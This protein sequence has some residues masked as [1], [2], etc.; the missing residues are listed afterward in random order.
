MIPLRKQ[1]RRQGAGM[2]RVGATFAL[3]VATGMVACGPAQAQGTLNE[4]INSRVQGAKGRLLVE[5]R[6]IVYDNDRNTVS[7]SGDVELNYQGRT[8]QADRVVY[9][10]N[11]GRVFAQG[12]VRLTEAN[13]SV[14][15][16]DQ[17]DLTDDFKSG[18]INSLQ[19]TQ[20]GVIRGVAVTTRFT[21]PRAERS[22][23]ETTTFERGTYTAC[24]PCRTA[25]EKPP[26]WQVKAA[27]IIHSNQERTIYY[28]NAT[29][30][31][32]GVP[33]A[34]LP[35][36]WSPDPTV[37]R[38]TGFLSPHFVQSS[39]LGTGVGIPFF[40][41]IA[42]NYDLT[43]TPTFLSRQGVLGQ[44]EFRHRLETGSYSIRAA[45]IYQLD[46][47]AFLPSPVGARE[48]DLRGSLESTG[49]FHINERWRTGW[50]LALVS[51][52]FFLYNYHIRSES[53]STTYN[54][55]KEA[56]STVFL[57]GQ[58]DRSWFDLRGYY[59][60]GLSAYDWQKQ[61]PVVHPVLDYDKRVNGPGFLGG[62]VSVTANL[63]SLTRE[64][65]AYQ[66][67]PNSASTFLLTPSNSGVP[68]SIYETCAVFQRGSCLVRGISGTYTRATVQ[69][70]WR[71]TFID[72]AGQSWTPFAYARVDGYSVNPDF[73]GYQNDQL[74]NFLGKGGEELGGRTMPAIGL[75]Y[76]YPFV[77]SVGSWGTQTVEPIAQVIARPNETRIG[78]LPNEDAQSLIFDDTN[79][80]RLDKFS[81]YDRV[82]GGVRANVGAQYTV[83]G[84]NQ[85]YA[86]ALV[87]QSFNI[88]GR[89]SFSIGDLTNTGRDSGL[90]SSRSDYVARLAVS[91]GPGITFIGRGRFD[92][93]DFSYR[94]LEATAA[95]T[96]DPLIPLTS[97]ITYARYDA[98]PEL[99]IERRR[100]GLLAA[101]SY[102][103]T[104]HWSLTGSVLVDLDR[105]LQVRDTYIANLK[106]TVA[107]GG[108]PST[109]VYNRA[110]PWTVT[111]YSLGAVYN[112][113]C[114][115]FS[116][117]YASQPRDL[118]I[119]V[120]E[121][122]KT[123]L[124][125]LELKTLGGLNV[126]Q[127]LNDVISTVDG[128]ATK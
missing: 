67:I 85:F 74:P 75:E 30:E 44:A 33:V 79:L 43:V 83:T 124:V 90:E 89:N 52:K 111:G 70:S 37:K 58:G 112:D 113:E 126:R 56:I 50:D 21:A 69:A 61:L 96:F 98:Q 76:R 18:F 105:Y 95:F 60:Q 119:G 42:P 11:T 66:Q 62:E 91:P 46:G 54:V 120:V 9:D 109:V 97:S 107:A 16:G 64:A 93:D 53:L 45:G 25:P 114:T 14:V 81:G 20:Q 47:T 22:E 86:N 78:R 84:P 106:A 5:A 99:G 34:F 128:I 48:R 15:T 110:D 35:Y 108:D 65:A 38:Q 51:D 121:P 1:G 49:L 4:S 87:G 71:R 31:F 103:F 73:S 24:E 40:W 94:R 80:F 59:I 29:L 32:A 88:A 57:Q 72:D 68:F 115:Q 118:A 101:S 125:R 104:P 23:G 63:T 39:A 82:E 27:R 19:V 26:L 13:G 2:G 102:K 41:A 28:E 77:G 117:T 10:R 12:N 17:F 127:N 36:F 3:M 8:L 55:F 7:A 116:V 100:E 92:Q 122:A 6:E 123:L